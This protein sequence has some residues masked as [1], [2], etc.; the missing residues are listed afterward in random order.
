MFVQ[1]YVFIIV[2]VVVLYVLVFMQGIYTYIPETNHV[3]TEQC[4]SYSVVTIHGTYNT[5]YSLKYFVLLH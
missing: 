1:I 3:S 2:G 4:C 5:I